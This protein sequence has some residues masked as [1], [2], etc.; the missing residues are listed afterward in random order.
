MLLFQEG[1][2]FTELLW[3]LKK[4]AEHGINCPTC[5]AFRP[6]GSLMELTGRDMLELMTFVSSTKRR[7]KRSTATGGHPP[8]DLLTRRPV[9]STPQAFRTVPSSVRGAS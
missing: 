8:V 3:V 5:S 2:A 6:E 1:E 4:G 9:W 7:P